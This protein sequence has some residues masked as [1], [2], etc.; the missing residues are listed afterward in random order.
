MNAPVHDAMVRA[1]T[2]N[3]TAFRSFAVTDSLVKQRSTGELAQGC[4]IYDDGISP[5]VSIW[6][7]S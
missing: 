1:H 6:L 2:Y 3:G 7:G 5:A 4:L